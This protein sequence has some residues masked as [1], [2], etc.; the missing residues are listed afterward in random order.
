MTA[1]NRFRIE[2]TALDKATSV[3]RKVNNSMTEVLQP[4]TRLQRQVGALSKELHVGKLVKGFDLVS[5]AASSTADNLGLAVTPLQALLGLG[6]AGGVV[7]T[8]TATIGAGAILTKTWADS[9]A[10]IGKTS[11][12]IGINAQE[13]QYY[14]RAA[15]QAQVSQD[16]FT[17]GLANMAQVL[18]KAEYGDPSAAA[19]VGLLRGWGVA[20]KTDKDGAIDLT[21]ALLDLADA[22]SRYKDPQTRLNM[23]RQFGMEG[24]L[25][26]LVH[27]KQGIRELVEEA[28]KLGPAIDDNGIKQ[29][30]EFEQSLKRLDAAMKSITNRWGGV[31]GPYGARGLDAITDSLTGERGKTSKSNWLLRN[32]YQFGP[33]AV[34]AYESGLLWSMLNRERV[35]ANPMSGPLPIQG[36]IGGRPLIGGTRVDPRDQRDR[37]DD[38]LTILRNELATETDPGA[39]AALQREIARAQTQLSAEGGAVPAAPQQ[40]V[41]VDVSFSNAPPGTTARISE[42]AGGL[43]GHLRISHVTPGAP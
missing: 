37:D 38:R 23:A 36:D 40:R 42:E 20:L 41:K 35:G 43:G 8:L 11:K 24:L 9:G 7:A 25:P 18:H 27:G 21:A 39:R 19:N 6:S 1:A 3:F 32:G 10:E 26:F 14:R 28:K 16:D 5:K 2:I 33:L 15:E 12:L 17:Q 13:L 30:T 22:I 34:P 4:A 31:L 29:A